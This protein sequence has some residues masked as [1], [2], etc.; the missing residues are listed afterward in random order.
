[1]Q[2]SRCWKC[3]SGREHPRHVS[4]LRLTKEFL[5]ATCGLFHSQEWREW[6][7]LQF[8]VGGRAFTK[9][10]ANSSSLTCIMS[11]TSLWMPSVWTKHKGVSIK[12]VFG[13]TGGRSGNCGN[14]CQSLGSTS[15]TLP[16]LERLFDE[17]STSGNSSNIG[18]VFDKW[19][20]SNIK[21]SRNV[22]LNIVEI[23]IGEGSHDNG[24]PE[25]RPLVASLV[26]SRTFDL[27]IFS[28]T[29]YSDRRTKFWLRSWQ[30]SPPLVGSP[31]ALISE[32]SHFW[33]WGHD[34][35]PWCV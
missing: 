21:L 15:D 8:G 30:S 6:G 19:N 24:A 22:E 16:T 7:H 10:C 34:I 14:G 1:M 33:P 31:F 12:C 27:N 20:S 25:S 4:T 9:S 5:K 28:N 2:N 35:W 17:F 3:C 26:L 29:K 23:E 18:L 13:T 11:K 32:L